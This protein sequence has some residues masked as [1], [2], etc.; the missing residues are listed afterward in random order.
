M[1][2]EWISNGMR[3]EFLRTNQ[4][5]DKT[6]RPTMRWDDGVDN[7]ATALGKETGK[8]GRIF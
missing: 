6:E 3:K 1:L 4:K 2:I 8:S 7:D 5:T